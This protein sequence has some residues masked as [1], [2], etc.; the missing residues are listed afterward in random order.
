MAWE[1]VTVPKQGGLRKMIA[2]NRASN[3]F[4]HSVPFGYL[5]SMLSHSMGEVFR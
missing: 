1:V 4:A 2:W 3:V 5:G